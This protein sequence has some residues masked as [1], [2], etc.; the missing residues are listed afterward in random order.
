MCRGATLRAGFGAIVSVLCLASSACGGRDS[1][2]TE[3]S[4][5]ARVGARSDASAEG[6]DAD[7][8]AGTAS[9][10]S[11]DGSY[12][13]GGAINGTGATA[14]GD[15]RPD[16]PTDGGNVV[17]TNDAK[18]QTAV[19]AALCGADTCAAG[20]CDTDG[21]CQPGTTIVQC[22][23][24][25]TACQ[26][27]LLQGGRGGNPVC[28]NQQC[29][30]PA[31]CACTTGC[32]DAL[33]ACQPGSS[34]TQCGLGVACTDCTASGLECFDQT[35]VFVAADAG[36]PLGSRLCN[37]QSCPSGCCDFQGA[38]QQGL[39]DLAC[40]NSGAECVDCGGV[41]EVCSNQECAY[42][43][44]SA[45]CER[46]CAG[47][48]DP[49]G[50]CAVGTSD[51]TCGRGGELCADCSTVGARCQYN[52]CF[53]PDGG[54]TCFDTCDGCCDALGNCQFGLL[55]TQCGTAGPGSACQDCTRLTPPSTCD[56]G[57]R[58]CASQQTACPAAY[59]GCP[60]ALTDEA[61]VRQ[62]VC[63]MDDLQNVASA[64]A[65]GVDTAACEQFQFAEDPAC[66]GCLQI[67]AFPIPVSGGSIPASGGANL[68]VTEAYSMLAAIRL[69]AAPFVDAACNHNSACL[70]DCLAQ[71]CNGCL[72]S[73][74]CE[75][76][77]QSGTCAAFSAT[78]QCI[79][80]ALAGPA[81][82]CNPATYQG[83]FGAWVQAVGTQ[84]CAQ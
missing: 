65:G 80:V 63:S 49:L 55:D 77:A 11:V 43:S 53:A 62:H 32:C 8:D 50:N 1:A 69:C 33:G 74:A 38:C 41:G 44:A 14:K 25:G 73:T 30:T 31:P 56:V 84:Y 12:D 23:S 6:G 9:G 59:T 70:A 15:A 83:N 29:G 71:A 78:D 39:A 28:A 72:S 13:T 2:Q 81:A 42:P 36:G 19:D 24:G 21:V 37:A 82:L 67:F 76:Q 48:C 47:C 5:D 54:S 10:E 51:T 52:T 3:A 64:C 7:V 40:G 17:A 34:N 58:V 27:C 4:D 26:S 66:L 61:P 22:G 16:T 18:G 20:C 75:T 46:T 60:A 35:C 57:A 79:T 68:V 45:A